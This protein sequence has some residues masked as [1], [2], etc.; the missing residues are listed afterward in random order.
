[1]LKKVAA[2]FKLI[3]YKNLFFI[4][5]AQCLLQFCI[6]QPLYYEVNL[7]P[8]ID[9]LHFV[10][11]VIASICIAAAGNV[12][13]DYFDINID[14]INKPNK[15]VVNKI[16]S[17]RWVIFWH[18]ALN[19]IGLV[20]TMYVSL[21][22]GMSSLF[23]ANAVCVLLLFIYSAS[24]KKRLLWGNILVSLLTAWVLMIL[25]IPEYNFFTKQSIEQS[26]ANEKMLRLGILYA[27]FSFIISLV[28]EVV[29]DVEDF[30]GDVKYGCK[31][32]PIVW[33]INASKIFAGIFIIILAIILLLIQIYVVRFGWWVSIC[34]C[35]IFVI[36]PLFI[37]FKKL[38]IAQ[39][40]DDFGKL[41]NYI[42][43]VML[44]GILSMIFIK[45]YH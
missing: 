35:I 22:I 10:L 28:R 33:G 7:V 1:M 15:L 19:L 37:V 3:R 20:C 40:K 36:T 25:I 32:M 45:W 24:L 21:K 44:T 42:K 6:I 16:I 17:R 30:E 26:A 14:L 31:T 18:L 27:G 4:V 43:L 38:L 5:L 23:I 9:G 8:A 11:I 39:S 2:F 34:Y 41:S 13:N 29:K 12:I